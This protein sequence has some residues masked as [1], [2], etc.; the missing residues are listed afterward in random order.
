M[1]VGALPGGD[2][3][4]GSGRAHSGKFGSSNGS[5]PRLLVGRGALACSAAGP[6][7]PLLSPHTT[8]RP[9]GKGSKGRESRCFLPNYLSTLDLTSPRKQ[10]PLCPKASEGSA[11]DVPAASG[12]WAVT[13]SCQR[14]V[15]QAVCRASLCVHVCVYE[16]VCA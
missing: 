5:R 3:G 6:G 9:Q 13:P 2:S 12:I 4:L 10:A 16:C 7:P 1:C 14:A 11:S 15:F 8:S